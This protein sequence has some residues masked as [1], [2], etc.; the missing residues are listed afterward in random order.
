MKNLAYL[1]F[2]F[3]SLS[4]ASCYNHWHYD[5]KEIKFG[6]ESEIH[7]Y[8][9]ELILMRVTDSRS[10]IRLN[11]SIELYKGSVKVTLLNP[12]GSIVYESSFSESTETIVSETFS[13][14]TGYW[15]L[16]Y[17]SQKGKGFIDLFLY[18]Q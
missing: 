11:G 10:P 2:V 3:F 9:E 15:K 5:F 6:F 18:R 1:M 13:A 4:A 17:E 7:E 12:E 14:Q 16:K 8:S